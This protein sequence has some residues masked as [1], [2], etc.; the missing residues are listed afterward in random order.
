ML[1]TRTKL[2]LDKLCFETI[3]SYNYVNN[4]YTG[5]CRNHAMAAWRLELYDF[6]V[7]IPEEQ[8]KYLIDT[9]THESFKVHLELSI[10]HSAI[11]KEGKKHNISLNFFD[12]LKIKFKE[13]DDEP[14]CFDSQIYV[15][16]CCNDSDDSGPGSGSQSVC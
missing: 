3:L 5:L 1:T 13:E 16:K 12:K 2:K 9:M 11:K 8:V 15:G 4:Q 7:S 10:L 6:L 14:L